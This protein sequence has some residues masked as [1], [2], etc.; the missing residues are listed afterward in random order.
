M[1]T[2]KLKRK[3]R[4]N[5]KRN[6]TSRK[7]KMIRGGSSII[8]T[9][10]Y[11]SVRRSIKPSIKNEQTPSRKPSTRGLPIEILPVVI[12]G[13]GDPTS[14]SYND[15][16]LDEFYIKNIV[17]E[18]IK[19]GYQLV[20]FPMPPS[21]SHSIIV[22]VSDSIVKI[23]DWNGQNGR[24]TT[25][26][27]WINYKKFIDYLEE[28]YGTLTY[29]PID[30]DSKDAADCRYNKNNGQGGCSEYVHTWIEKYIGENGKKAVL[31]TPFDQI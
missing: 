7:N 4:K 22:N 31:P 24:T 18:K 11:K 1:R 25:E 30:G 28:K 17:D 5:I 16:I 29:Y 20:T 8:K 12:L 23:V 6:K 13:K 15:Q 10:A 3:I 2:I 19:P 21:E 9:P 26:P 27:K 14:Y